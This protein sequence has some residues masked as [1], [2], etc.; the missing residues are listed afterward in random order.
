MEQSVIGGF[1]FCVI[2]LL[3][4]GFPTAIWHLT[5]KWKSE[6]AEVPSKQYMTLL[7]ILSGAFI[8]FGVLL[9]VGILR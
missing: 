9:A 5:E 7:R 3:L 4:C 2:G 8:G 6:G 1:V